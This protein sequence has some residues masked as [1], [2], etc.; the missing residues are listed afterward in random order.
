M[1]KIKPKISTKAEKLICDWSKK[2]V[3]ITFFGQITMKCIFKKYK[4]HH[5]LFSMINDVI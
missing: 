4:N 3:I 2:I 5:S 1:K